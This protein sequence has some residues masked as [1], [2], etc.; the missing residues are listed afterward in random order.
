[1]A[2]PSAHLLIPPSLSRWCSHTHFTRC[3][4]T[5]VYLT[6]G[7][8]GDHSIDITATLVNNEGLAS[9]NRQSVMKV[10]KVNKCSTR[11]I[12]NETPVA[13]SDI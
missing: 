8:G 9:V 10:T 5:H 11:G 6:N 4:F 13:G 12:V 2:V 3:V 7:I 1:M